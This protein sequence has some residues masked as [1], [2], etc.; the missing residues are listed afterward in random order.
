MLKAIYSDQ[1]VC[2]YLPIE[3]GLSNEKIRIVLQRYSDTLLS[4][5]DGIVYAVIYQNHLIGYAGLKYVQDYDKYEIYYGFHP[6][7]WHQGFA[8]ET[9]T[10]IK[11][12]AKKRHLDDVIAFSHIKNFASQ[13]VLENIG[14][15]KMKRVTLWNMDLFF[16]QMQ[17]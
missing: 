2:Q 15:K 3:G 1:A 9:A 6:D 11:E 4:P 14:Y 12:I 7:Y 13:R 16:Y 5:K 10:I 8:I 17:L